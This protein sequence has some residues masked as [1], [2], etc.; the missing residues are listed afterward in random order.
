MALVEFDSFRKK[1]WKTEKQLAWDIGRLFHKELED[2]FEGP[3]KVKDLE[4]E[5]DVR[6]TL[7]GQKYPRKGFINAAVL[8][9][10]NALKKRDF[11]SLF[12]RF[13]HEMFNSFDDKF[14]D[15]VKRHLKRKETLDAPS[16][17]VA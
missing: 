5:V 11:L 12:P 1:R 16:F 8:A 7:N 10:H 14:L 17:V 13:K 4:E 2:A 9:H 15:A 6:R 3:I